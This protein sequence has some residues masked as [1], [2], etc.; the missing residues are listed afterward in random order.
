MKIHHLKLIAYCGFWY[1]SG[2]LFLQQLNTTLVRWETLQESDAQK[3]IIFEEN[4]QYN[5]KQ[6]YS[7][8]NSI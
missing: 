7:L 6:S 8:L 5:P 3:D 1:Y 4:W 2:L